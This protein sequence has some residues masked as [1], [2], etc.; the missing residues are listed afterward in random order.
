MK[1]LIVFVVLFE[2]FS[3]ANA[4]TIRGLVCDKDTKEPIPYV[5]VYLDG[6]SINTLTDT[7][8]RFRLATKSMI[9]TKLVLLQVA[10]ETYIIDQ[11]FKELPD[12]LFL[13]EKVNSLG[14]VEVAASGKPDPFTRERKMKAFREQFLGMTNAGKSCTIMNEDDIHLSFDTKTKRLL[15]TSDAPIIVINNYLGYKIIFTLMDFWTEYS[16]AGLD[17]YYLRMSFFST[18]SSFIDLDTNNKKL[19]QRRD[20]VYKNSSKFFFKSF[21]DNS[22]RKDGFAVYN[23]NRKF[24]L[25]K[26]FEIIDTLSQKEIIIRPN[27]DINKYQDFFNEEAKAVFSVFN[28]VGQESGIFFMTDSLFVDRYGNIDY[29]GRVLF[30]G[31]MSENKAGDMLPIDYEP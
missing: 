28:R 29:K 9:N 26:Y 3:H 31:Q 7:L 2:C 19:K 17:D 25:N 5:Y 18:A 20:E 8:G 1:K 16:F 15:A 4:Q 27:T 13:E 11:P 30:T 22:L 24:E 12:T 14:E 10:Y 23:K 21:T 6:T